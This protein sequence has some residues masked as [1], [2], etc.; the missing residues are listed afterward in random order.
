MHVDTVNC[1]WVDVFSI[2]FTFLDFLQ[3]IL[4]FWL[5][6][7]PFGMITIYCIVVNR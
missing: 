3:L 1:M 7:I 5:A 4:L 6:D 2:N